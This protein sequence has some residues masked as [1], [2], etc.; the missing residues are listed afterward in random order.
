MDRQAP[1]LLFSQPVMHLAALVLSAH[2]LLSE[3]RCSLMSRVSPRLHSTED[4]Y[5]V[6]LQAGISR[7]THSKHKIPPTVYSMQCP[8]CIHEHEYWMFVWIFQKLSF[9][10]RLNTSKS[11]PKYSPMSRAGEIS[12]G[13]RTHLLLLLGNR[14]QLPAS[15]L[16]FIIIYNFGFQV[17]DT[18]FCRHQTCMWCTYI[19]QVNTLTH[20]NKNK[21]KNLILH[22]FC[23]I[24][25][26]SR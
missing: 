15:I 25:T 20:I 12:Q 19:I 10:S 7:Q 2:Y 3:H 6:L 18:I 1:L 26:S 5:Y 11:F 4:T 24:I 9:C 13:L 22:F 17:L 21:S 8:L 16:W 14:V 23:K